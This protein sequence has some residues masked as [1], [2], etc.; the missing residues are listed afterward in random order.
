MS[1]GLYWAFKSGENTETTSTTSTQPGLK[2]WLLLST[3]DIDDGNLRKPWWMNSLGKP[4]GK[5]GKTSAHFS[6]SIEE[7][8]HFSSS[9]TDLP[10]FSISAIDVHIG[11][12]HRKSSPNHGKFLFFGSPRRPGPMPRQA[13]ERTP[14]PRIPRLPLSWTKETTR[15]GRGALGGAGENHRKMMENDGLMGF[16]RIYDFGFWVNYNDLTWRPK[17]IDDG[18]CK[19]HHPLLWP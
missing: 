8:R 2:A 5:P 11:F 6:T 12:L 19:G 7:F 13:L 9:S 3:I 17:P 1:H 4:C 16:Y 10:H 15:P 18:E 14:G